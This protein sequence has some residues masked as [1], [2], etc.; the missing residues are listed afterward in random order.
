LALEAW[1]QLMSEGRSGMT[2]KDMQTCA[3]ALTNKS[4]GIIAMQFMQAL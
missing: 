1:A 2:F 4:H 3:D